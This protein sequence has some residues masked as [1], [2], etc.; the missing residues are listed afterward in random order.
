VSVLQQSRNIV[1]PATSRAKRPAPAKPFPPF[2]QKLP[3]ATM[4]DETV[5][6]EDRAI[7]IVRVR[8]TA[9]GQDALDKR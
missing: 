2:S 3:A 1:A 8:I 9:A 4:A 7:E 6:I 5:R